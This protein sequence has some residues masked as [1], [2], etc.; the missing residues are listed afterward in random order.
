MQSWSELVKAAKT[1]GF[2][3]QLMTGDIPVVGYMVALE[4]HEER[5]PA[6]A[7]TEDRLKRYVRDHFDA[8]T[9]DA[10]YLGAWLE[11]GHVYLDVSE[12]VMSRAKALFLGGE[13]K[14]LAVWDVI[15]SQSIAVTAPVG[16]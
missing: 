10:R 9:G 1:E 3:V 7:F 13:R 11:D 5:V 2:S 6:D 8:L 14:Q 4:G 15:N 16:A 12:C